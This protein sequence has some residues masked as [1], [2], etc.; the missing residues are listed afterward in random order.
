[1]L[2]FTMRREPV[3]MNTVATSWAGMSVYM[4]LITAMSSTWAPTL[5]KSSLTGIPDRPIGV[6]LKGEPIATP[7]SASV[8]PSI[9]RSSGLGSQV[10]MWDGA[11][12]AKIWM[13]VF[14]FAAK[15]G[16]LGARG[17]KGWATTGPAPS[18]C[19]G[20]SRVASPREPR[21]KPIRFRNC[22]RLRK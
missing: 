9:R 19:D 5:V 16:G 4:E 20:S 14:A 8:L 17:L 18:S 12:W 11:P 13:T 6:N 1:M 10:S 3:F 15:W 2:G 21:P 7:P 22:R